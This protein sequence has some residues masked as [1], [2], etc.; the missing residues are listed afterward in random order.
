MKEWQS[1]VLHSKFVLASLLGLRTVQFWSLA[2]CK[3]GGGRPGPFYHVNDVS[4]YVG[5][6]SGGGVL[7]RMNAFHT[8]VLHI[9]LGL[10]HVCFSLRKLSK[11]Q[12]LGQKQ[13]LK[14][15]F[16]FNQGPLT[17]S[18]YVPWYMYVFHFTN[19]FTLPRLFMLSR[20]LRDKNGPRH[21]CILQVIKTGW[22]EGLGMMLGLSLI[23][24]S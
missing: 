14:L 13:G 23:A 22:W 10:V 8:H 19:S 24:Y 1:T 18:V 9:E 21:F 6:Q 15:I 20:Y 12:H 16:F 11:L 3:N 17:H 5:R 2:V 7:D 4:V